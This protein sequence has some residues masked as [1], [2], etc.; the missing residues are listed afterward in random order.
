MVRGGPKAV[1]AG[2]PVD[3][4]G[5]VDLEVGPGGRGETGCCSGGAIDVDG[6]AAATADRVVVVVADAGVVEDR[7]ASGLDAATEPLLGHDPQGVIDRLFADCADLCAHVL[8]DL[9]GRAM[10]AADDGAQYGEALGGDLEPVAAEQG[11]WVG[12]NAPS[13]G[14]SLD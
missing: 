7:R 9:V 13:L 5:L 8:G 10:R 12:G 1:G 14:Q 4:L 11:C 2:A 6:L 3:D